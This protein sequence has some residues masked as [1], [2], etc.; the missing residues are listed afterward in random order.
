MFEFDQRSHKNSDL[1]IRS[2]RT[3]DKVVDTH[4]RKTIQYARLDNHCHDSVSICLVAR[5]LVCYV[6]SK[7]PT[8][9]RI[10]QLIFVVNVRFI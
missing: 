5:E 4:A 7:L 6:A 9:I 3:D 1:C 2:A 10:V 8:I